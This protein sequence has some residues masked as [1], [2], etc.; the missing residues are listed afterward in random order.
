[1]DA[2]STIVTT[3]FGNLLSHYAA[4]AID[5][6]L[7]SVRPKEESYVRK[8]DYVSTQ[9]ARGDIVTFKTDGQ[10]RKNIQTESQKRVV[11]IYD[12][13]GNLKKLKVSTLDISAD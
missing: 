12:K 4:K 9:T 6:H 13:S 10:N 5:S 11:R 2:L 7:E 8:S 1:M 3:A